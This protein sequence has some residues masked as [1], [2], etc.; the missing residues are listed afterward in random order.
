MSNQITV[1]SKVG[2]PFCIKTKDFFDNLNV[3]FKEIKLDPNDPNY[4]SKR[5]YLFNQSKHR[6]FPVIF[7]GNQLLGGFSDLEKAYD[8]LKLHK[9]CADINIY[10]PYDF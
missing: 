2:C 1:Y 6:S 7:I 10:I 4:T 5:D 8:T 3:P 9:L